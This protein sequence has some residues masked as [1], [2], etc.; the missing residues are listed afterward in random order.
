MNTL[1]L[2]G[3]VTQTVFEFGLNSGDGSLIFIG[4]PQRTVGC[5]LFYFF[6]FIG[7]YFRLFCIYCPFRLLQQ[8]LAFEC[9]LCILCC[10]M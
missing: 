2:H 4:L 7:F 6:I 1:V 5:F 9:I 10:I 3:L 8:M